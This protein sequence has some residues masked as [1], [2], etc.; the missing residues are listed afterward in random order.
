MLLT[1]F[2]CLEHGRVYGAAVGVDGFVSMFP[3]LSIDHRL[4]HFRG[5]VRRAMTNT[6][7]TVETWE[8]FPSHTHN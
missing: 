5:A 3:S 6:V 8:G 7:P 2:G 4:N 1:R